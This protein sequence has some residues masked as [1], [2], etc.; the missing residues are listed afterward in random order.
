MLKRSLVAFTLSVFILSLG[1]VPALAK[2]REGDKLKEQIVNAQ[3]QVKQTK[4][5]VAALKAE[6]AQLQ[7]KIRKLKK[8]ISSF[9]KKV[10]SL[11]KDYDTILEKERLARGEYHTAKRK[12]VQIRTELDQLLAKLWPVHIKNLRGKLSG[13][14]SWHEADRQFTW[15][16]EIYK[17]TGAKFAELEAQAKTL[18]DILAKRQKLSQEAKDKLTEV[19]TTKDLLLADKI[20][21]VVSLDSVNKEKQNREALLSSILSTIQGL[22]YKLSS[23]DSK[24]INRHKGL[25][26]PP[27]KGVI[28]SHFSPRSKPPRRGIAFSTTKEAQVRSIFWGKVVHNDTLRGFGRVVILYHGHNMYS[29]YAYLTESNV[30]N[31]QEVEKDEPI[32]KSGY[33]PDIKGDGLYFELRFRQKPIN[34]EKWLAS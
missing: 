5:E 17:R 31:G 30:R 13:I 4:D 8:Q 32:G 14:E 25:L 3:E 34:P 1:A 23:R 26:P 20:K 28:M 6:A 29:L 33:Y 18:E 22:N 7:G 9:Q 12:L 2:D 10:K 19:N 27:V 11:Q 16:S 21:L 24:D 15:L